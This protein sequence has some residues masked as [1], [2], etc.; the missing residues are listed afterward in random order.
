MKND[1]H[2]HVSKETLKTICDNVF[3]FAISEPVDGRVVLLITSAGK[4]IYL[5][6]ELEN[7]EELKQ[8]TKAFAC[9]NTALNE[10]RM[11]CAWDE[12]EFRDR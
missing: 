4:R 3:S 5:G 7:S 10:I 6:S 8:I 12:Y 1:T 9:A 2:F 11:Q